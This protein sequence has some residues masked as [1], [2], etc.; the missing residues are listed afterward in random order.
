MAHVVVPVA[1]GNNGPGP[2]LLYHGPVPA[3]A[4]QLGFY[5]VRA[6]CRS[7][8]KCGCTCMVRE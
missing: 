8:D 1:E 2:L 4:E 5:D 6:G 7:P 3:N